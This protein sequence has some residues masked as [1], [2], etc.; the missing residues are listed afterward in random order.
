MFRQFVRFRVH[1]IVGFVAGSSSV[2]CA[3]ELGVARFCARVLTLRGTDD[4]CRLVQ[5]DEE[6]DDQV[7]EERERE[8][9]PF[10]QRRAF[11][12]TS[13]YSEHLRKEHTRHDRSR[14][15]FSQH[16]SPR[17]HRTTYSLALCISSSVADMNSVPPRTSS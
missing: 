9:L 6:G 16:V 5:V 3:I 13:Y 12:Q 15:C 7:N 10:H 4:P 2:R 8:V 11:M 1:R 14:D 17:V